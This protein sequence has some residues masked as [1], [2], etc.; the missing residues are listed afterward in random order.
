MQDCI[1]IYFLREHMYYLQSPINIWYII[2]IIFT[3]NHELNYYFQACDFY[4]V[5]VIFCL[6]QLVKISAYLLSRWAHFFLSLIQI[7]RIN[8]ILGSNLFVC[9]DP[10]NQIV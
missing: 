1:D 10:L 3:F 7:V 5:L 4:L 2:V 6:I 9:L 8:N